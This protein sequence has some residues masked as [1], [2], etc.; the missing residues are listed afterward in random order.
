MQENQTQPKDID[1]YIAGFPET[2]QIILQKIRATI[3]EAAPGAQETIS[4][5]MPTYTLKGNLVHFAAYKR[6]IGFYPAPS[7]I[8]QFIDELA[9]YRAGKG[10]LNF[11]LDQPV[12]YALISEIVKFRVQENLT[13]AENKKRKLKGEGAV[14][15]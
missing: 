11:P 3:R 12:P 1:A 5:R 2:I 7:G 9:I 15:S 14:S 10:S 13:R 6:H 4:Y 8:D